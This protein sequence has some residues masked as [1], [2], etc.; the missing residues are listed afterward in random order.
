MTDREIVQKLQIL[1]TTKPNSDWAVSA[2]ANLLRILDSDSK[3]S[4]HRS[5]AR[6]GFRLS[7]PYAKISAGFAFVAVMLMITSTIVAQSSLPGSPLYK[8][9]IAFEGASTI[10]IPGDG[11]EVTFVERRVDE[12]SKLAISKLSEDEADIVLQKIDGYRKDIEEI[13]DL[14]PLEGSD[15][16]VV[17]A[18]VAVIKQQTSVLTAAINHTDSGTFAE[19]LRV[20]IAER[21][22]TCTDESIVAE[23]GELLENGDIAGLI[24]ANELSARCGE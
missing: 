10:I 22:E 4:V 1:R 2:R 21:V 6:V 9:K 23:I 5:E 8:I 11:L 15:S 20:L 24:E 18:K 12:A 16:A 13:R 17:L 7:F 3:L 14:A 19:S